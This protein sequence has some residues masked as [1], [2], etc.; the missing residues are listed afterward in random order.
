MERLLYHLSEI[1]LQQIKVGQRVSVPFG[2]QKLYTG[3]V[4]SIYQKCARVI[5]NKGDSCFFG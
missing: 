1:D 2:T 4:H 5:Q 3:I